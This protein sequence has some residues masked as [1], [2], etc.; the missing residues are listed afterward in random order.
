MVKKEIS[1]SKLW[2]LGVIL[3]IIA[4]GVIVGVSLAYFSDVINDADV[5]YDQVGLDADKLVKRYYFKADGSEAIDNLLFDK[6]GVLARADAFNPGDVLEVDFNIRNKGISSLWV[7]NTY[8]L[9]IEKHNNEDSVGD[10]RFILYKSSSPLSI[11]DIRNGVAINPIQSSEEG[12]SEVSD[13]PV[14]YNGGSANDYNNQFD[15]G[16]NTKDEAETLKYYLYFKEDESI[17]ETDF[18]LKLNI[19]IEAVRYRDNKNPLAINW[20]NSQ[21]LS[22]IISLK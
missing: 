11:E 12:I 2:I 21:T 17:S 10:N 8:S 1:D 14:I 5:I 7:K 13:T 22:T 16:I 9:V 15:Q 3:L 20:S 6:N 19:K 4:V 18:S